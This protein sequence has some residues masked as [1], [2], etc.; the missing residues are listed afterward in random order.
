M[1]LIADIKEHKKA[2]TCFALLETGNYLL[3]GSTDKTI[4][5]WQM[6]KRKMEC[7]EVI[8]TKDSIQSLETCSEMIFALTHSHRL[9]VFDSS[10]KM[11]DVF[12]N[13]NV[14][15]I[16]ASIGKL[17]IGCMDSSIQ[18]LI[19]GNNRQQEIKAPSKSWKL[20][21]KPINSIALYKDWLYNASTSIDGSRIKELRKQSKPQVSII[22]EKRTIAVAMSI[23]EDFM[24]LNTSCSTSYLEIW[25]RGT[26]HKVGRLSASNKITSI[27]AANDMIL[28]GTESGLIKTQQ[29]DGLVAGSLDLLTMLLKARPLHAG[30]AF[31]LLQKTMVCA[32]RALQH[33]VGGLICPL[34]A[35]KDGWGISN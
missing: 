24:Y 13:K 15:C 1:T 32:R 20:Q 16:K 25:L 9:K 22:P 18:E 3:S 19:I 2:V 34:Y 12:K 23:V 5:I 21:N 4:R 26:H 29:T 11:K 35:M 28:C 17:Y 7:I 33:V 14:T 30:S 6:F 31:F 8:T 27:L 10:R